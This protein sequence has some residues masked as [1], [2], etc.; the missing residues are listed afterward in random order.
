MDVM[1]VHG[2]YGD[3]ILDQWGKVIEYID[4]YD[5]PDYA[6]II[7]FNLE[8]YKHTYGQVDS[9]YDILDLGFWFRKPDGSIG[10]EPPAYEWRNN[11]VYEKGKDNE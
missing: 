1:T 10:Y 9:D 5:E 2:S 7:R 11:H 8:E 4:P 3:L 6:D